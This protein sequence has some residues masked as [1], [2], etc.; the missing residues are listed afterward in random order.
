MLLY[1]NVFIGGYNGTSF[2][3]SQKGQTLFL[4]GTLEQIKSNKTMEDLIDNTDI[5]NETIYIT[6]DSNG[7]VVIE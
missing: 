1:E 4:F 6:V 7:D 5:F 2:H 3:S